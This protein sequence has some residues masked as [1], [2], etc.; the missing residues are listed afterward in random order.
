[1]EVVCTNHWYICLLYMYVRWLIGGVATTVTTILDPLLCGDSCVASSPSHALFFN[2]KDEARD[3]VAREPVC[4]SV[5]T[6][7]SWQPVC[8]IGPFTFVH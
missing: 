3:A 7:E 6:L 8:C 5:I 1:M 4:I 2:V